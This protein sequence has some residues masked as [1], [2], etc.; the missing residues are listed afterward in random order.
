[1]KI[2]VLFPEMCNLFGDSSN[3]KYLQQCL[4]QAKFVYTPFDSEPAFVTEEVALVY[5]GAMTER[6]Q[7]KIADKLQPYQARICQLIDGQETIF[8]A[9]GNACEVFFDYMENEDGTRDQGLG[10]FA[11]FYAK[12]DLFHRYNGLVWGTFEGMDI[13]GFKTQFTMAYGDNE[14]CAFMPVNRGIGLNKQSRL[15]GVRRGSFYGTYLVGPLLVLNP[16]FTRYLLGEMGVKQ[17]QLAFAEVVDEA[18]R[19]RLAEF[20]DPKVKYE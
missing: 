17:P 7:Q 9:T 1:M 12:R 16:P 8:L 18:Y 4:P 10:I 20:K 3:M 19:L 13:I 6:A 2:E 11:G 5:I 14:N 15:E